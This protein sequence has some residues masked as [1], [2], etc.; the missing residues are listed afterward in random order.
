[1]KAKP[2]LKSKVWT[3]KY[4]LAFILLKYFY[5]KNVMFG[6]QVKKEQKRIFSNIKKSM[7]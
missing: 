7:K 4:K 3:K 5:Y 2:E 6:D 1:M